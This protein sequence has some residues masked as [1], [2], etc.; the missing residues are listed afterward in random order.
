MQDERAGARFA[1]ERAVKEEMRR[2][3]GGTEGR[4]ALAACAMLEPIRLGQVGLG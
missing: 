2:R 3:D 4:R 1:R